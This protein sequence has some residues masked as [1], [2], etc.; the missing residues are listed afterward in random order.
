MKQVQLLFSNRIMLE[1]TKSMQL[2]YSLMESVSEEDHLT[3]YYGIKISKFLGETVEMDEV[4]GISTSKESV[5]FILKKLFQFEVTP[6]SMVE[7]V[8]ELV[9]QGL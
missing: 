2:D 5:V 6:I 4:A 9:T 1:D 3:P 8:D 7:I